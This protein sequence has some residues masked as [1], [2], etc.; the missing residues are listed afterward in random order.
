MEKHCTM[1]KALKL[2]AKLLLVYIVAKNIPDLIRYVKI[3]TM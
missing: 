2:S 1:R 3:S